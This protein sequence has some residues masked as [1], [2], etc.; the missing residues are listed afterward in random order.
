MTPLAQFVYN[1]FGRESVQGLL[2]DMQTS[3]RPGTV[4]GKFLDRAGFQPEYS[5]KTIRSSRVE[6]W[7]FD[8]KARLSYRETGDKVQDRTILLNP[9]D[10]AAFLD[11]LACILRELGLLEIDEIMTGA[12]AQ[13]AQQLDAD[14]VLGPTIGYD[15][16]YE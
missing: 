16:T 15:P 2:D 11:S 9:D 6:V 5:P 8:G 12:E 10:P 14:S 7:F 3:D 13:D 4:L 1:Y